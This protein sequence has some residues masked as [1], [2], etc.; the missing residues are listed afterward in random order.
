MISIPLN[1]VNVIHL[2]KGRNSS[3]M[4]T[5]LKILPKRM[6]RRLSNAVE[7]TLQLDK[8]FLGDPEG[9]TVAEFLDNDVRSEILFHSELVSVYSQLSAELDCWVERLSGMFVSTCKAE[10]TEVYDALRSVSGL[11][12]SRNGMEPMADLM[13]GGKILHFHCDTFLSPYFWN[14]TA[15]FSATDSVFEAFRFHKVVR[16]REELVSAIARAV[17]AAGIFTNHASKR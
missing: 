10:R 17:H 8:T 2:L 14:L 11:H 13:I 15:Q 3:E 6:S 5:L 1:Q 12:M 9:E 16:T 7:S 4:Q